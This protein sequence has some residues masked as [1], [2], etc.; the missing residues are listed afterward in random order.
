MSTEEWALI[1]AVIAIIVSIGVPIFQSKGNTKRIKATT[2][3]LLLQKILA[4]K[5]VT[6]VSMHELINLLNKYSDQMEPEQRN[7]LKRM[8]PRMR[9]HHDELEKLHDEW[10]NFDDKKSLSD[11]EKQLVEVD[12]ANSE[13][14]DTA[15]LIENGRKSY[16]DI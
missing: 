9:K 4:A 3:T 10:S 11:I 12:V 14:E 6:F 8:L 16:E 13:A 2:R 5:S 7:D 1:V 15:K